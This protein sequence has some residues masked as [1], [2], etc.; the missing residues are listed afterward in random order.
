MHLTYQY[1]IEQN[2]LTSDILK[3]ICEQQNQK[4]TLR[5]SAII[6]RLFL[7]DAMEEE[8]VLLDKT[9]TDLKVDLKMTGYK[10]DIEKEVALDIQKK[11]ADVLII[12]RDIQITNQES[13]LDNFPILDL[14]KRLVKALK[15]LVRR[16]KQ[17]M[18]RN[19]VL[20]HYLKGLNIKIVK[21]KRK[22]YKVGLFDQG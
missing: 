21:S 3:D 6:D 18:K 13:D 7:K 4:L 5:V 10:N 8:Q 20:G 22:E 9:E 19:K 17:K 11:L 16:D 1:R 14:Q 2:T 12:K 15:N